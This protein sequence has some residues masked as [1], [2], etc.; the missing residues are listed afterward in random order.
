V[1]EAGVADTA[2]ALGKRVLGLP[3]SLG[4]M[5]VRSLRKA[6][7]G[8]LSGGEE[9][10]RRLFNPRRGL[11]EGWVDMSGLASRKRQLEGMFKDMRTPDVITEYAHK[12][13]HLAPEANVGLRE[14]WRQGK[15]K[16]VAE[17]LSRG[18]W[19]GEG[20]I[21]KYL[22]VG[23]K[24]MVTGFGAAEIPGIVNAQAASP[25]GEGARLERLGG[26][27]GGSAGW[28]AGSGKM[29]V[30]PSMALWYAGSK[31]GTKAGRVADRLRAGGTVGQALTAPSP[32]EARAQLSKIYQTYGG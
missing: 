32:E 20:Q 11:Q 15:L 31:A 4:G 19:T 1:K 29:G 22:P 9:F 3:K 7:E 27:L 6:P 25:T 8:L 16:G 5:A 17:Q 2:A 13:K 26:L 14:A 21:T 18:G 12:S 30:L 10:G 24:G 28:I 23:G